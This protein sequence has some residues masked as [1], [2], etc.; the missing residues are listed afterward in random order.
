MPSKKLRLTKFLENIGSYS[1]MSFSASVL[2][3]TPNLK[4]EDNDDPLNKL[5]ALYGQNEKEEQEEQDEEN[6]EQYA[7]K[8]LLSLVNSENE[9]DESRPADI[10]DRNNNNLAAI[11]T[12]NDWSPPPDQYERDQGHKELMMAISDL[13]RELA[14]MKS[15]RAQPQ[16]PAD[17]EEEESLQHSYG[18]YRDVCPVCNGTGNGAHNKKCSFC[19]GSGVLGV[20]SDRFYRKGWVEAGDEDQSVEEEEFTCTTCDG[21]GV[22]ESGHTCPRCKGTGVVDT[23]TPFD[24]NKNYS[25]YGNMGTSSEPMGSENGEEDEEQ[26]SWEEDE[27]DNTKQE[28]ARQMFTPLVNQGKSRQEIIDQF[29]KQIGVTNSTAVSY[30]QRLAK[31]AGLTTSGD[32][33]LGQREPPGLGVAAGPDKMGGIN[34]NGSQGASLGG[35]QGE[36][37]SNVDGFEVEDDPDR[38]GLIRTVK[39]AHLVYKRK[40]EDGTY[41]ELWVFK[42]GKDMKDA[43]KVRRAILAGTD[44]PP[45]STK[46]QDGSQSYTLTSLGNG[47]VLHIKGLPN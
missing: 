8:M 26:M 18:E 44:I 34:P 31:E 29:M 5:T 32:R 9:E 12:A 15:G 28:R 41:D 20:S 23:S 3:T 27:S 2:G 30:Y 47:Q 19:H 36:P 4:D 43:L 45:K 13:R 37:E 42:A 6:Q 40:Q 25:K 11:Q 24:N 10:I 39:G 35:E 38:Q 46:S 22:D 16:R 7:Q 1:P 14:D 33:E 17:P 21:S